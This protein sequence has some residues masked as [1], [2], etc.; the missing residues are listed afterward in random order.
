MFQVVVL[1]SAG[2]KAG[3]AMEAEELHVLCTSLVVAGV[4]AGVAMV[5]V[6][7]GDAAV[8]PLLACDCHLETH[9][10]GEVVVVSQLD[11]VASA[12][13]AEVESNLAAPSRMVA[14]PSARVLVTVAMDAE[15]APECTGHGML[16]VRVGEVET[17]VAMMKTMLEMEMVLP[18]AVQSFQAVQK[19]FRPLKAVDWIEKYQM[20]FHILVHMKRT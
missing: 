18:E 11:V 14:F 15:L 10:C 5:A 2:R 7:V 1:V 6:V 13:D 20:N 12:M 4:A 8:G 9:H 19:E 3:V 16:A 17:V